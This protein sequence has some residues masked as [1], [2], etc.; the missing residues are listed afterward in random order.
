MP[1]TIKVNIIKVLKGEIKEAQ[2]E[3]K[4]WYGMCGYG[5]VV[6]DQIYVMILRKSL[7]MPGIYTTVDMGCSVTQLLVKSNKVSVGGKSMSIE[8]IAEI[9]GQTQGQP[10]Y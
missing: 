8:D 2:I 7:E 9:I 6:D 3:V 4:S 5:I 1:S 10:P